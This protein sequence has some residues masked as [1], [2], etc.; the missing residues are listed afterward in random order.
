M[1]KFVFVSKAP[2][3]KD[4]ARV[5]LTSKEE[6]EIVRLPNGQKELTLGIGERKELTRRKFILALRKIISLAK[7]SKIKKLALNFSD[8]IFEPLKMTSREVGELMAQ[9][10]EMANFE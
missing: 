10:F 2:T 7:A 6:S 9:N 5:A 3:G 4:I 1:I 8:F